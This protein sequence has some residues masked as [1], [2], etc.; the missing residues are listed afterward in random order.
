VPKVFSASDPTNST[1]M[2]MNQKITMVS[3]DSE[4]TKEAQS[5]TSDF[6]NRPPKRRR[7]ED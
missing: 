1:T 3:K 4:V 7:R 2:R 6:N 5:R